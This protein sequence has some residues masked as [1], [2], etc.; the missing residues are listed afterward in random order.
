M[1][2]ISKNFSL[3]NSTQIWLIAFVI[4]F[5]IFFSSLILY[6]ANYASGN[7][8][9]N[10]I[11]YN[12]PLSIVSLIIFI[13]LIATGIT[14]RSFYFFSLPLVILI[15]PNSVNDL[16]PAFWAGPQSDRGATTV[17]LITHLDLYLLAGILLFSQSNKRYS[18]NLKRD[19]QNRDAQKI[20]L[21]TSF[22]V[23][24][25]I[26]Y[27]LIF[28]AYTNYSA[29]LFFGNSF[30]VRYLIYI[31]LIITF[32]D[33]RDITNFN[34]GLLLAIFLVIVESFIY[35]A[36]FQKSVLTSGN[37]GTNTLAVL[38]GFLM[39]YTLSIKNIS[40]QIKIFTI[41]SIVLALF[42]TGTRSAI[43]AIILSFILYA[44]IMKIGFVRLGV[45]LSVFIFCLLVFFKNELILFL[46]PLILLIETDYSFLEERGLVGGEL[47]SITTRLS[48]WITSFDLIKDFPFGIGLTQF[49]FIKS[50]YGFIIP[51]FIDPHNDYINFILK[52]GV[53]N[54]LIMIYLLI[55]YSLRIN[56][57]HKSYE[58]KSLT[59]KL[60][61]FITLVGF[62]NSNFD[63]HQF[64]LL[65]IFIMFAALRGLS[66][67][68]NTNK[69]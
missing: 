49:N 38:L 6:V 43:L 63:K 58:I 3:F 2:K 51:V 46:D 44:P 42:F 22:I 5:F 25:S 39:I 69:S 18:D 16:L 59:I 24:S 54:G 26:I 12:F 29:L 31:S 11:D 37:Y 10:N 19:A 55:I 32:I 41:L 57:I 36:L 60:M 50:E 9:L 13:F 27:W 28:D 66:F 62:S 47:S 67:K 35:T 34:K 8:I 4:L 52:Y 7:L 20:I 1:L 45:L 56:I 33:K 30:Q 65:F 14:N 61:L 53:I 48:L 64:F 17:S 40:R 15:V 68:Y 21:T 23:I